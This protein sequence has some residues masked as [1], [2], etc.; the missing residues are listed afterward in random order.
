MRRALFCA[1][2]VSAF[3]VSN[4]SCTRSPSAHLRPT[5]FFPVNVFFLVFDRMAAEADDSHWSTP[6]LRIVRQL[7]I[8]GKRTSTTGFFLEANTSILPQVGNALI[9]G[10]RLKQIQ[11]IAPNLFSLVHYSP[12]FIIHLTVKDEKTRGETEPLFLE[13]LKLWNLHHTSSPNPKDAVMEIQRT[14]SGS[15]TTVQRLKALENAGKI[16]PKKLERPP[17][18]AEE[19]TA[20]LALTKLL[21]AKGV[22]VLSAAAK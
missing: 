12:D 13:L 1:S 6:L 22:R 16:Q 19:I 2:L 18:K 11:I 14:C 3:S 8:L 21:K 9:T 4:S 15:I 10:D 7:D 17:P 20:E 5:R